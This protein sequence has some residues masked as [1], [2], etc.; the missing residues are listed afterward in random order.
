VRSRSRDFSKQATAGVTNE[1]PPLGSLDFR[2]P[3]EAF[4]R[5]GHGKAFNSRPYSNKFHRLEYISHANL[6]FFFFLSDSKL[7]LRGPDY[8][9]GSGTR[10]HSIER[11]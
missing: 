2:S 8:N 6:I 11:S 4:P 1:P 7:F 9:R 10:E 3:G 5:E